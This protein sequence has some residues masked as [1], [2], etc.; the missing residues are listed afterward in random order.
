[1][2]LGIRLD[3]TTEVDQGDAGVREGFTSR[4][5]AHRSTD[6]DLGNR[7][8]CRECVIANGTEERDYSEESHD[9]RMSVKSAMTTLEGVLPLGTTSGLLATAVSSCQQ[10]QVR[11]ENDPPTCARPSD[12]R[13]PRCSGYHHGGCFAHPFFLE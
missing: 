13:I 3:A 2:P 12:K 10:P 8:L 5:I 6:G 4:R 7:S 1:M 11:A 9:F